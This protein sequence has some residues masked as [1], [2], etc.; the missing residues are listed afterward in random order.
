MPNEMTKENASK[1]VITKNH[2]VIFFVF[3]FVNEMKNEKNYLYCA[4]KMWQILEHFAWSF[5]QA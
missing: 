2:V 1:F 4:P 3:H 5:H